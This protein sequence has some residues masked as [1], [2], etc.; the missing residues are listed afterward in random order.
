MLMADS[1]YIANGEQETDSSSF[2]L[3]SVERNEDIHFSNTDL[4]NQ[5]IARVGH[6]AE[7]V[8]NML[9]VARMIQQVLKPKIKF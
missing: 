6:K 2:Q 5:C 9:I 4:M 8:Y 1:L 3:P 7:T